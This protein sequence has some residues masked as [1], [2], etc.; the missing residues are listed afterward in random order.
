MLFGNREAVNSTSNYEASGPKAVDPQ[1]SSKLVLE[2]LQTKMFGGSLSLDYQDISK[3]FTGFAAAQG[4]GYDQKA[5]DQLQKEKGLTRMGFGLT[6]M[7]L[8]GLKLSNSFHEVQDNGSR[9][10][11][12]SFGIKEGPLAFG[13]NSQKVGQSFSRFNDLAEANHGDLQRELGAQRD[14]ANL[15]FTVKGA[16]LA[17][18]Q[19]K[20]TD[21]SGAKLERHDASLTLKNGAISYGDS[22]VAQNFAGFANLLDPEKKVYGLDG[23]LDRQWV[24]A[25]Y[26][27]GHGAKPL[28]ASDYTIS[29]AT[30]KFH[31]QDFAFAGSKWSFGFGDHGSDSGNSPIFGSI[32]QADTTRTSLRSP[33]CIPESSLTFP[34][35][36]GPS[37]RPPVSID[38]TT[39]SRFPR[40]RTRHCR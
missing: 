3:N 20:V 24:S 2:N 35:S 30:G 36:G 34:E 10:S 12:Q 16:A 23:G 31:A 27:F 14:N 32:N 7:N 9:I 5:L 8:G 11:W 6:D 13:W 29:S 17:A 4:S 26:D 18:T 37:P 21:Q 40:P 1:G 38:V 15:G 28:V 39:I 25:K 33:R 22:K 19:F